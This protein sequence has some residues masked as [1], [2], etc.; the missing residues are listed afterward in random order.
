MFHALRSSR[1][2]AVR[3]ADPF[4]EDSR[5]HNRPS[6]GWLAS[7]RSTAF[8]SP[9]EPPRYI[10]LESTVSVRANCVNAKQVMAVPNLPSCNLNPSG[11]IAACSRSRCST[12]ESSHNRAAWQRTCP[13]TQERAPS[14]LSRRRPALLWKQPTAIRRT[15]SAVSFPVPC[16]DRDLQISRCKCRDSP[17]GESRRR[18]T[19]FEY[20]WPGHSHSDT[21][22]RNVRLAAK[23]LIR[24]VVPFGVLNFET[25]WLRD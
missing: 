23:P 22:R 25:S 14:P 12:V 20:D 13:R 1:G 10:L 3:C 21:R 9:P 16:D 4:V 24:T 2:K 5:A 11:K 18:L 19:S 17:D 15:D 6:G 8:S 7:I